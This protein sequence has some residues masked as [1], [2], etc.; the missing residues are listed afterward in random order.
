M[1]KLIT[2]PNFWSCLLVSAAMAL[3]TS[4]DVL[5]KMIGHDGSPIIF[6]KLPEPARRRGHHYQEIVDCA[7]KLGYAV[8]PIEAMPYATPDGKHDF[9]VDFKISHERRLRN[10]LEGTRGILTG[11]AVTWRHAVYWNGD[12][13]YDPRGRV[14]H[15]SA[16]D[17]II[18]T[19]YRFDKIVTESNHC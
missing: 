19:Y 4:I 6:P 5:I 8:T 9:P 18:D 12:L 3:D 2:N 11:L 15:F 17:I 10:H 14:Y 13:V 16:C 7:I 1:T